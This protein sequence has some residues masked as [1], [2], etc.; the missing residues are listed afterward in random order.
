MPL[1]NKSLPDPKLTQFFVATRLQRDLFVFVELSWYIETRMGRDF[2][3]LYFFL[4]ALKTQQ[5]GI[6]EASLCVLFV[7]EIL[8]S[9]TELLLAKIWQ[10]C[11]SDGLFVRLFVCPH[12]PCGHDTGRT[13]W[14]IITKLDTNMDLW[15]GQKPIVFLGQMSNN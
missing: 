5:I 4:P 6:N 1:G 14:P 15:S 3:C 8:C 9:S 12:G 10:V 11:S 13:V 2:K 7:F